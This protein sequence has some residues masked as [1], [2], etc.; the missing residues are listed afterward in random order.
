M[1]KLPECKRCSKQPTL[2]GVPRGVAFA[3][4]NTSSGFNIGARCL[5]CHSW[6]EVSTG[7][8]K[9]IWVPHEMF[10][11]RE[12]ERM[13]WVDSETVES[14]SVCGTLAVLEW[15]HYAPRALFG[16]DADNWPCGALCHAC[17]VRWHKTMRTPYA[18]E[19][20]R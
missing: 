1:I 8:A 4:V 18:T 17:H 10:S 14:C 16:D 5:D 15:H 2:F 19:G 3:R 11:A 9:G 13:H 6:V 7:S 12:I 20:D